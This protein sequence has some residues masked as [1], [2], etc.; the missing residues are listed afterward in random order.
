MDLIVGSWATE[1]DRAVAASIVER[2]SLG[3]KG[4][5]AGYEEA[6]KP[7][8]SGAFPGAW[9]SFDS[10]LF[11]CRFLVTEELE[12]LRRQQGFDGMAVSWRKV[13][14][15][16][17]SELYS[18]PMIQVS[19]NGSAH[20]DILEH[21][22]THVAQFLVD[23]E[24]PGLPKI[25]FPGPI[26]LMSE[27]ILK[28]FEAHLVQLV[29]FERAYDNRPILD[30]NCIESAQFAALRPAISIFLRHWISALVAHVQLHG[31]SGVQS[32]PAYQGA[33]ELRK[34]GESLSETFRGTV[35]EGAGTM[36]ALDQLAFHLYVQMDSLVEKL[37][38]ND[39]RRRYL[40]NAFW[41][42]FLSWSDFQGSDPF[43]ILQRFRLPNRPPRR[44]E[45]VFV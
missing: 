32:F 39:L 5:V 2:L 23:Y 18:P 6:C 35:L 28:E 43:Q 27:R 7:F 11:H 34:F 12:E 33:N 30:F 24:F 25:P 31:P 26:P 29:Y 37:P 16:S 19:G 36:P 13:N 1:T 8:A 17:G 15:K 41:P 22:A 4:A 44:N 42:V 40:L 9:S 20:Q 3:L 38:A 10:K 14:Q 21:E 45:K